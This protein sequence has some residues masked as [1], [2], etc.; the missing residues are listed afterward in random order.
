MNRSTLATVVATSALTALVVSSLFLASGFR[1]RAPSPA[2]PPPGKSQTGDNTPQN[3]EPV[4][5]PIAKSTEE[6]IVEVVKRASPAV[7]S[8]IITKDLPVLERGFININ[9][10]EGLPEEFCQNF[11][12]EIQVP[13]IRE[14]G[15]QKQQVGSGSGFIVSKDGL[16]ITNKHVV[17]D[18]AADYTVLTND[19]KR[20]PARVLARDPVQD[21]AVLKI[22]GNNF[23]ML[24][25]GDSDKLAIGRTVIAIGNALGEFQ[26][27]VSVGVV[28]GLRRAITA[29][30]G[31]VTEALDNL[32]QTDAAINQ[33]NSGGPLLNLDGEVVGV[34]TA[35]VIGA[36]SIG[37]AI[38]SAVVKKD[39]ADVKSLGKISVPFL[40]VRHVLVTKDLAERLKLPVDYGARVS[41][42]ES[43]EPAVTPDSPAAGAGIKEDDIIVELDGVRITVENPLARLIQKYRVGDEVAIKIRRGSAEFAVKVKLAERPQS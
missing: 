12:P 11:F 21:I 3:S 37:F 23:P 5:T 43:G 40:G 31:G 32:I 14:R 8:V 4:P 42:G 2:L 7:V 28:S 36:Q 13:Q 19:G 41:R 22:E 20:F 34:N 18:T 33:G 25:I 16:V 39:L 27:T 10:C 6:E 9:P 29:S 1:E 38:P 26:N 24:P 35:T 17:S 15:T 30:G